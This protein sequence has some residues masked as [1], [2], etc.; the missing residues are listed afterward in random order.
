MTTDTPHLTGYSR[1]NL[2]TG[3]RTQ[4][5][6]PPQGSHILSPQ[7]TSSC[8]LLSAAYF[9]QNVFPTTLRHLH[10]K[11]QV[12]DQSSGINHKGIERTCQ[13]QHLFHC[14]VYINYFLSPCQPLALPQ[15]SSFIDSIRRF[16]LG[17][18]ADLLP[19]PDLVTHPHTRSN[20]Y[21]SQHLSGCPISFQL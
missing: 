19:G 16:L 17:T 14:P 10:G 12:Y 3:G 4:L 7:S 15:F 21:T 20:I 6:L 13:L 2:E 1:V 11:Y 18:S 9:H 5:Q 8:F